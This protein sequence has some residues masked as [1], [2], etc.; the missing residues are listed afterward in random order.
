MTATDARERALADAEFSLTALGAPATWF[1]ALS[2]TAPNDDGT[3]FTEP[4]GG[5]YARVS[6]T[7]NTT[8]FPLAVTTAGV[9]E[10]KNGTAIT[11]PNPTADWGTILAVGFFTASSG[12]TVQHWLLLPVGGQLVKNG[13]TPVEFAINA[14]VMTF[15]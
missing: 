4:V 8:N 14:L 13:N 11:F 1:V 7:N 10:K 2:T 15:D 5:S 6:K 12:G 9:T 3:N